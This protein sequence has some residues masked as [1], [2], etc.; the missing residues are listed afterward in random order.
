MLC[1]YLLTLTFAIYNIYTF[2]VKQKRYKN[3]LITIFYIFSFLV[4]AFRICYYC[5][6]LKIYAEMEEHN[7][8]IIEQIK[9]HPLHPFDGISF[10]DIIHTTRLIGCFFLSADYIKYALGFFQ[11]ASIA[12]L[13]IVIR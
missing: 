12:E 10:S 2:L 7:R 1:I 8:E 5:A 9:E 11:L 6:V 13:T 3:W 4:L